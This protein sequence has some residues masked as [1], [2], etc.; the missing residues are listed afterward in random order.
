[1]KHCRA[2]RLNDQMV[3][4]HCSKSW[5]VDDE[6]P[7]KCEPKKADRMPDFRTPERL[8]KVGRPITDQDW[9]NLKEALETQDWSKMKDVLE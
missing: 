6:D 2:R 3:C 4:Y 1:M 5:D 8:T 7:P 9:K